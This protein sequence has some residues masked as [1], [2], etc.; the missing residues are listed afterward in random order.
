MSWDFVH[1]AEP[2]AG[3][4]CIDTERNPGLK[5]RKKP[6]A[7]VATGTAGGN[8][9]RREPTTLPPFLRE[10]IAYPP[11]AGSGVHPWL[12]KVAR[13]LHAHRDP[14]AIVALLQDACEGC[15]RSVPLAEIIAAVEDSRICAWRPNGTGAATA[16]PAPKWP[17]VDA[18]KRQAAIEAAG[19]TLSDLREASPATC[20]QDG[21]DAEFFADALFPGNPLLCVGADMKHF[22]TAPREHFRGDLGN[23]ALIVPS[24]MS[25]LTGTRKS[26]GMESAHTLNNTG[27][28]RYLITEFD[29]GTTDEQAALLWHLRQFAPLVL[30]LHSGGKSLHGWWDCV[31][32]DEAVDEAVAR[33]FFR[34]A[35]TLGADP[36]TWTRSQFVRL[37][38][39]W[40]HDKQERQEVHFF[41]PN[42]GKA[43]TQ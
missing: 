30:V 42:N 13:Q 35:V 4:W 37:P 21:M 19:M 12:F 1:A 24:P 22:E 18:A 5:P 15:G 31:G 7:P 8:E 27:P 32:V 34:Y 29:G 28:R 10:M 41:D 14:Q 11:P 2:E 43:D 40:R 16:K 6:T 25:A 23:L 17:P 36:A 39:G 33:R 20:T 3:G 38:Q 9:S 26:D